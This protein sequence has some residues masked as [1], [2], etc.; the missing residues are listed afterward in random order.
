MK[1]LKSIDSEFHRRSRAISLVR[2]CFRVLD[3]NYKHAITTYL[4]TKA[5]L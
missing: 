2:A 3:F 4:R 5:L 1:M